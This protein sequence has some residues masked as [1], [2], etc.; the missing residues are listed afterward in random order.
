MVDS[1]GGSNER[2]D[3]SGDVVRLTKGKDAMFETE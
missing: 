1:M 3:S 2:G